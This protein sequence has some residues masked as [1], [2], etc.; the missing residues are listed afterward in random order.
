MNFVRR[1]RWAP[2]GQRNTIRVPIY[3]YRYRYG[4]AELIPGF[5]IRVGRMGFSFTIG[6]SI[7]YRQRGCKRFLGKAG[8]L[9][10][11]GIEIPEVD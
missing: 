4:I 6:T 10:I 1:R 9:G 11:Q 3:R 8:I 5:G 2:L 7:Q